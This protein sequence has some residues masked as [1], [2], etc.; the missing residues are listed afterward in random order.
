MDYAEPGGDTMG[1]ALIRGRTTG[2]GERIGSLLFNFGGPGGSGVCGLPLL[3]RHVR[4]AARAVRP[5]E[6]RPA[7][8]G[9]QRGRA[10]P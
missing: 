1:I 7:R 2:K 10:V 4:H 5:G 6:L 8:G 3:R 9:G